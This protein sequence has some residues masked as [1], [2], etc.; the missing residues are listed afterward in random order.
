[1]GLVGENV[2]LICCGLAAAT[3]V[4][5]IVFGGSTLREND[6]LVEILGGACRALG[7]DPLFLPGGEFAGA[8]GALE[9]CGPGA[10]VS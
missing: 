8:I 10:A 6:A 3:K 5:R 2:A 1:M 7:R 9:L 4:E